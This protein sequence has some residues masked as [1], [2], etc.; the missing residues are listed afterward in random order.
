MKDI[1][2]AL[3]SIDFV[4]RLSVNKYATINNLTI[5]VLGKFDLN[6]AFIVKNILLL[7]NQAKKLDNIKGTIN[8]GGWIF[9]TNNDTVIDTNDDAVDALRYAIGVDKS[10]E[11]IDTSNENEKSKLSIEDVNFVLNSEKLEDTIMEFAK[12][13]NNEPSSN[14]EKLPGGIPKEFVE[15][16]YLTNNE[17]CVKYGK[18]I[19]TIRRWR[20]LLN[21]PSK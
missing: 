15:D 18:S 7:L 9:I 19:T 13:T 17:L 16:L 21:E 10:D 5:K 6:D 14:Q 3:N 20:R 1:V 2:S 12:Y 8:I 4:N 11:K